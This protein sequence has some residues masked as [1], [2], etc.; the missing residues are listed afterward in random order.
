MVD[1]NGA[2]MRGLHD[3]EHTVRSSEGP[4][5]IW[6]GSTAQHLQHVKIEATVSARETSLLKIVYFYLT[7]H[8][9]L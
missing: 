9:M 6:T 5:P 3:E 2:K 7:S 8:Y 4:K 1:N